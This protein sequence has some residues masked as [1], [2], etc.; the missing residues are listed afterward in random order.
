MSIERQNLFSSI[1]ILSVRHYENI[2]DKSL[3]FMIFIAQMNKVPRVIWKYKFNNIGRLQ[4]FSTAV[5]SSLCPSKTL[6]ELSN[7]PI[8][9]M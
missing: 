1:S 5:Q 9:P 2:A 4:N 6:I 7:R 3:Y 8:C